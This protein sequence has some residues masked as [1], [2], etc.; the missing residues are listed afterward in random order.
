MALKQLKLVLKV[1]SDKE[2]KLRLEYIKS[3]QYLNDSQEKL[4]GLS[5]FKFDYMKQLQAKGE[6][7]LTGANYS[8]YQSFIAKI[9]NAMNQQIQ[10]INTAK[11]VVAQ[12]KDIWL[13][14]Q[15]KAKAIEKLIEKKNNLLL[16]KRNKA[17]QISLDEFT[18][19]QF[20]QRQKQL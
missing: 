19:N 1:T 12:R 17:E 3:Q 4:N 2:E 5:E 20:I 18:T 13:E 11:Q 8:H 9:E 7:G 14:Q 16:H 10:V 6:S 15:I